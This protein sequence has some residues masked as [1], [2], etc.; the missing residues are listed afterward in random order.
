MIEGLEYI[1]SFNVAHL[2]IKLE[3]LLVGRDYQLK[4]AD[5]DLSYQAG[6]TRILTRGSKYY[7]APELRMEKC[8][9]GY[10][11]DIYSAAI[12]LFAMKCG[13]VV[14]LGEGELNQGVD[15]VKLLRDDPEEFFR[16]HCYIQQKSSSFFDVD[17][18]SLF[19]AMTK[20]NPDKRANIQDIKS[21]RWYKGSVYSY[22]ELKQVGKEIVKH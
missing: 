15:Y 20:S 7:R 19:V 5:F 3:N 18:K 11:A 6:D 16:K 9:D 22:E 8:R 17:F 2:D 13:G 14:P 10:A 4:I 21:S 12:V 1:H